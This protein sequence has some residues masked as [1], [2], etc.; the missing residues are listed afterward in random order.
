MRTELGRYLIPDDA[1]FYVKAAWALVRGMVLGR[2]GATQSAR[3]LACAVCCWDPR[4]S[5]G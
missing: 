4:R 5:S 1:P 3:A 2:E